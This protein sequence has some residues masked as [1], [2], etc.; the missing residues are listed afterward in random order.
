[1]TLGTDTIDLIFGSE[2]DNFIF[3]AGG[4]DIIVGGGGNDES[5]A[6]WAKMPFLVVKVMTSFWVI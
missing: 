1:M 5:L 2:G 4:D 3:G 6:A